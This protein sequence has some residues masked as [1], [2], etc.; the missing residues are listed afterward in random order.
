MVFIARHAGTRIE[1]T[2]FLEGVVHMGEEG[3]CYGP[4]SDH[5]AAKYSA[6]LRAKSS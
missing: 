1:L 5:F 2:E 6:P 3:S 4:L